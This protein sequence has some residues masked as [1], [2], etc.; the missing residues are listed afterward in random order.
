MVE[1]R[2]LRLSEMIT[3]QKGSL[4]RRFVH[5]VISIA[6]R[7]FFYRIQISN[8]RIVPSQGP[9]IFVLNHPNGLIDP[10][11]VF[12]ALPRRV[13][14]LAKST[15]FDL[16]VIGWML[17][18]VEALPLY[19]RIDQNANLANNQLTFAACHELLQRG[20]CIA[21]FPE[22]ISHRAPSLQPIKTGAARIALGVLSV[23]APDQTSLQKLLIIPA[24]LYYTSRT[25]FRGETLL[26][27]GEP[28]EITSPETE[29]NGE[30]KHEQVHELT[31]RIAEALRTVTLNFTDIEEQDA[32]AKAETIVSSG[33]RTLRFQ[34][35]LL[36][37][38]RTRTQLILGRRLKQ[39]QMPERLQQLETRLQKHEQNL[40]ALGLTPDLLQ[41]SKHSRRQLWGLAWR[42]GLLFLLFPFAWLG[43]MLHAPTYLIC[44][45]LAY[46]F[47]THGPDEGRSTVKILAAIVLMPLTWLIIATGIF[48]WQNWEVALLAI[49]VVALCG[50]AGLR[51]VEEA[52]D[53]R[54]WLRALLILY[55]RRKQFLKLV[56]EGRTLQKELRDL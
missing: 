15:L 48:F 13:S 25:P 50:Y 24:G 35:S 37:E 23:K 44:E 33:Y 12:C 7:L 18:V 55:Q 19:R 5:L 34:R 28:L 4:V 16:P 38:F 47:R 46:F 45:V 1:V 39:L 30:P 40:R 2:T 53:L 20:R 52:Y 49:P 26:Q 43:L 41:I 29:P 8:A 54:G 6:L 42:A 56:R 17:R 36:E 14:F 9:L 10:A 31:N 21:L 11:M 22:G 51:W 3:Q 27:F 32:V